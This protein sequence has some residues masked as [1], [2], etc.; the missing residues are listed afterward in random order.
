MLTKKL[1][2]SKTLNINLPNFGH[3]LTK[4][5]QKKKKNHKK[6]KCNNY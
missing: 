3:H 5:N 1:N 6:V 4:F 2:N